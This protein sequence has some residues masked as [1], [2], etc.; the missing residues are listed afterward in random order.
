MLSL[1]N[2]RTKW[3]EF[4]LESIMALFANHVELLALAF[5]G[6]FHPLPPLIRPV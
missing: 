2:D 6:K 1:H 5:A 4:C 3:L